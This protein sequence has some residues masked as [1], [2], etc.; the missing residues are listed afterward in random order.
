MPGLR[1]LCPGCLDAQS[2]GKCGKQSRLRL[3][4]TPPGLRGGTATPLALPDN[5]RMWR[6]GPG[7][8]EADPCK[9]GPTKSGPTS[10]IPRSPPCS[11]RPWRRDWRVRV[12]PRLVTTVRTCPSVSQRGTETD[13][14]RRARRRL[15]RGAVRSRPPGALR[16][17]GAVACIVTSL[18]E[19]LLLQRLFCLCHALRLRGWPTETLRTSGLWKCSEKREGAARNAGATWS[20]CLPFLPFLPWT[21]DGTSSH[22]PPEAAAGRARRGGPK[23]P[24]RCAVASCSLSHQR[25]MRHVAPPTAS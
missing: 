20:G 15:Q 24:R 6:S 14:R 11:L 18:G 1:V 3:I 25:D 7:E 17:P 10:P 9:I 8:P 22:V 19:D 12:V 5:L 4:L 23:P 21:C 16:L 2:P 13:A